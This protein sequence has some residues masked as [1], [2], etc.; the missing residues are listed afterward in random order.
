MTDSITKRWWPVL[1]LAL[2][3][4]TTASARA[5]TPPDAPSASAVQRV[6]DM[7]P[8][9]RAKLRAQLDHFRAMSPEQR[10]Q[11]I[12]AAKTFQTL[13]PEERQNVREAYSR[14]RDM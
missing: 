11:L 12:E 6:R 14:F 9:E 4:C 10:A 3:L 8:E 7:S 5:Q 1:S 2:V 13:S